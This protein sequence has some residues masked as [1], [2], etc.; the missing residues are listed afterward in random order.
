MHGLL[1]DETEK[2]FFFQDFF[3]FCIA[4]SLSFYTCFCWWISDSSKQGKFEISTSLKSAAVKIILVNYES[5][6]WCI[7]NEKGKREGSVWRLQWAEQGLKG[8]VTKCFLIFRLLF[9]SVPLSTRARK[10]TKRSHLGNVRWEP[11]SGEMEPLIT[12]WN[13]T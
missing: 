4:F 8:K 12:K 9:L 3:G 10:S 11:F 13:K 2:C 1:W 6:D 5:L 7:C